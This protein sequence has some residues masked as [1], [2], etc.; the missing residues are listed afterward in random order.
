MK[1]KYNDNKLAEEFDLIVLTS[2]QHALHGLPKG[3]LGTLTYSYT[4]FDRPLY[5][6]FAAADGSRFEEPLALCDFRVLNERNDNDLSI[7]TRF[8]KRENRLNL[9]DKSRQNRYTV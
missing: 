8:L 3:T 6:E 9:L 4:G 5:A 1:N 7:I 2:D